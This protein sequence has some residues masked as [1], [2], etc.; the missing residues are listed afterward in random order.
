MLEAN[1]FV[2]V[3]VDGGQHA[4]VQKCGRERAPGGALEL[5]GE[6][7]MKRG[8]KLAIGARLGLDDKKAVRHG[9]LLLRAT[10]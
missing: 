7:R 2:Q 10:G 3:A 4:R 6:V 1:G 5:H 9:L 8:E